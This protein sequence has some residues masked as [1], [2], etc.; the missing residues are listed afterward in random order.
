MRR[1][2]ISVCAAALCLG[3]AFG[4]ASEAAATPGVFHPDLLRALEALDRASGPEAYAAVDRIWSLWDRAEAEHVEEALLGASSEKKLSPEARSYAGVLAAFARA[5]R[6]DQKAATE[7]IRALGYVSSFLVVGPF[8]NEGK[9]GLDQVFEPEAELL[10]PITPGRA[11]SG[12][13]RPVRYRAVA[14]AFPFGWLDASALVRP[15]TKVCIYATTFVRDD[16]LTTGTRKVRAYVGV[17]GAFKLFWNGQESLKDPAYRGHDFDR[18]GVEL[19]LVPGPN[20]LLVKVC[21]EDNAPELSLRVA[22]ESGAPDTRLTLGSR[23]RSTSPTAKR[24]RSACRPPPRSRP[25]PRPLS[26]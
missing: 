24:Q 14:N 10:A 3:A 9:G 25:R 26:Q 15:E 8:D 12:K 6:G 17:G 22:D 18:A 11:Y 2:W 23:L 1:F 19:T 5:R 4:S 20:P 16:K 7:R 21:G 13:E